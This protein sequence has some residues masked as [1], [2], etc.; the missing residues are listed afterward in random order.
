MF[1]QDLDNFWMHQSGF[2]CDSEPSILASL[3]AVKL[4]WTGDVVQGTSAE[5][6]PQSNSAAE[7]SVNVVKGHVKSIKL[8]VESASGV[9]VPA[10][11]DLSSWLVPNGASV[12]RRFAVGRDDK[13]AYERVVKSALF[14]PWH[15]SVREYGGCLCSQPTVV[16]V[17]S[18]SR[19][20]QGRFLGP[21]DG[22]HSTCRYRQCSG[23]GPNNQTTAK[24]RTMDWQLAERSTRRRINTE[25]TG[26]RWR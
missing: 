2:R 19:F 12:H 15:R 26:R 8:A 20:E 14:L 24:G 25:C 18:D 11:H 9:D 22:S 4:A 17:L 7:S 5:G 16:L 23:E 3:R 13:T 21:M 1:V 6:D 10:D